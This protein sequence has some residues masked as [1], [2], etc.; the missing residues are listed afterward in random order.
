MAAAESNVGD[1]YPY[2]NALIWVIAFALFFYSR[3]MCN[4]GVLT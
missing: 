4:K 3:A 2:M 1:S